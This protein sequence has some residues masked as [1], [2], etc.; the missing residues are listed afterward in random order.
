MDKLNVIWSSGDRDV[1][2]KLVFMYTLNSKLKDWW[3][4]VELIVWGPSAKLLS[5][6]E[7]LQNHIPKMIAAGVHIS[8]CKACSDSYGISDALTAMGIEVRYMGAPLTEKLKE[9][10][11]II[12]F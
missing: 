5:E 1:A 8:A 10:Q 4:Y 12:T 11:K 6:D 3:E 7:E 9:D 2:L